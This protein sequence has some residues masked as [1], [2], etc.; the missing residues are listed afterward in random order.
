VPHALRAIIAF[1]NTYDSEFKGR[2]IR[3]IITCVPVVVVRNSLILYESKLSIM[4]KTGPPVTIQRLEERVDGSWNP[5][6]FRHTSVGSMGC[7][8]M[9]VY[10]SCI[11]AANWYPNESV[12]QSLV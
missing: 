8:R 6:T 2:E 5:V 7:W 9:A 3:L 11:P 4:C 1:C 12:F 10:S